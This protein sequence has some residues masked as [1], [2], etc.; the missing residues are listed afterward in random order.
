MEIVTGKLLSLPGI[1]ITGI[2]GYRSFE[3]EV[4]LTEKA[5]CLHCQSSKL[6]VK[7]RKTRRIRH[8]NFGDNSIYLRYESRK[9]HCLSCHRYFWERF[10]S[11]QPYH[12]KTD[13]FRRQVAKQAFR[14]VTKKDLSE[15]FNIGQ[16]TAYRYFLE[17]LI[18]KE[19][20]LKGAYC[21]KVLGIDEHFFTKKKGY[22]T[23]FCDLK[24][25]RVFDVVL[26][27]SE[28]ALDRYLRKLEGKENVQVVVIDLSSTY[29][30]IVRKYFPNAKLVSDRFHVIRL[31]NQHFLKFWREL[32]PVGSKNRGLLSLIRRHGHKLTPEQ[33]E[34]LKRY[35]KKYPE[36]ESVYK[37]KQKLTRLLTTKHQTAKQCK[38][39]IPVFL[40]YIKQLK[41]SIL[42]S[43]VTL[44]NTLENWSEEVVRMWRFTKTNG[45]TE[46][47]HNKMKM[48][49]RRAYGFR[50]F[51]NY[52]LWVRVLCG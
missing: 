31:V 10:P 36:F 27:R 35:F 52:R 11:V 3:I 22:V 6:H 32:D 45:I 38:R 9:F 46:G 14:G 42:D 20:H 2:T 16:A 13:A 24:K 17:E 1:K 12:Q 7:D 49:A 29:R 30:N 48:L 39:L 47:F 37:F 28:Q 33:K 5:K 40:N 21:P 41:E 25:N 15:D 8:K 18:K 19:S 44:G 43:M 51:N 34:K 4:E 50:N 23:T 26:G